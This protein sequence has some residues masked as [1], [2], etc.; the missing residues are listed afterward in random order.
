MEAGFEVVHAAF[1][2]GNVE[3]EM[4]IEGAVVIA[5]FEEFAAMVEGE[6][7]VVFAGAVDDDA[8]GLGEGFERVFDA[9]GEGAG[10]EG[11]LLGGLAGAVVAG[12]E[13][14]E[15]PVSAFDFGEEGF[16]LFLFGGVETDVL[17]RE[18]AVLFVDFGVGLEGVDFGAGAGVG[19]VEGGF[20]VPE[21][22]GADD[23]AA[24]AARFPG[25]EGLGEVGEP[26]LEG[27]DHVHPGGEAG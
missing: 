17:G 27:V 10:V 11:V 24:D 20:A 13:E 3:V 2:A 7:V 1:H 15:I 12:A 8:V 26:L 22:Q 19:E 5:D 9:G 6:F 23:D 18:D 4:G 25:V 16:E 21:A 14:H